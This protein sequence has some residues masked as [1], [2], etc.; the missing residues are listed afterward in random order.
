[1]QIDNLPRSIYWP[2]T[3]YVGQIKNIDFLKKYSSN[4]TPNMEAEPLGNM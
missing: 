3:G 4:D 2:A 1:M